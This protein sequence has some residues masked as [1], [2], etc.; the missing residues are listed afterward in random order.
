MNEDP[1]LL[2][3][4]GQAMVQ[5]ALLDI[6]GQGELTNV[7]TFSLTAHMVKPTDDK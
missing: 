5:E 3:T 1:Q 4:G 7:L 6:S 2:R